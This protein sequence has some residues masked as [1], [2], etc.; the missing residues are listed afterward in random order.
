[1]SSSSSVVDVLCKPAF[2][3]QLAIVDVNTASQADAR[4]F[5]APS[6]VIE[7]FFF[8]FIDLSNKL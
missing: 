3:K 5:M 6:N 1:M 4:K 8:W 2:L 7:T